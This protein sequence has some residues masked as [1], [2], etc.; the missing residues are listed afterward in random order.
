[1][2]SESLEALLNDQITFELS[3]AQLY[4]SIAAFLYSTAFS[5]AAS[6]FHKKAGEETAHADGLI[7]YVADRRGT[8]SIGDVAGHEGTDDFLNRPIVL[9]FETVLEHET[10]VTRRISNI[11]DSAL[12]ERDYVTM[13]F[14]ARYLLEQ[15]EEEASIELILERLRFASTSWAAVLLIDQELGAG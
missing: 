4:R 2:L 9:V 13:A 10:N 5:G 14:L 3:S 1:M 8:V 7:K 15:I 6:Y 12:E 11:Y